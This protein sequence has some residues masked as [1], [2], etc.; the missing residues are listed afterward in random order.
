MDS[1]ISTFH[2][3]LKLLIAQLVNFAVVFSVLY[4]LV[5]K[6]LFKTTGERSATIEKSLKEAKEI[7]ERLAKTKAEQEHMIHEAKQQAV[8]IIDEA[9]RKAELRKAEIVDKAKEE[10]GALIN[11]E[12]SRMQ[13]EKAETLKEI[14]SEVA[15]MIEQSWHKI[16]GE[17]INKSVDEKIIE[18]SLKDNR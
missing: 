3:D 1:L 4:F 2:L 11:R 7:E 10:V 14:R 16:L 6:P 9:S 8:A 15:Q 12:K 18:K 13:T 17:K 5:F